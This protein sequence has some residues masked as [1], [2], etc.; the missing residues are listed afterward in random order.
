MVMAH[1]RMTTYQDCQEINA[2]SNSPSPPVSAHKPGPLSSAPWSPLRRSRVNLLQSPVNIGTVSHGVQPGRPEAINHRQLVA[3]GTL[4]KISELTEAVPRPGAFPDLASAHHLFHVAIFEI[5]R[6]LE[7]FPKH[8]FDKRTGPTPTLIDHIR[9][10]HKQK[11]S[12]P[13]GC[14]IEKF[15]LIH[16]MSILDLRFT[17]GP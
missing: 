6:C 5:A 10:A 16:Q 17:A 4:Q 13:G 2:R 11:I 8:L 7:V 15:P 12:G 1:S 3:H 14:H 9:R